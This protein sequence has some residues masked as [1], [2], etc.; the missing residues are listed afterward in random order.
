MVDD[1]TVLKI[2]LVSLS[3][4]TCNWNFKCWNYFVIL[5]IKVTFAVPN[6]KLFVKFIADICVPF[7]DHFGS[8]LD[9][10]G[11]WLFKREV[12]L[13]Q[14]DWNYRKSGYFLIRTFL[15]FVLNTKTFH[16]VS[17]PCHCIHRPMHAKFTINLI[18]K[19]WGTVIFVCEGYLAWK[20]FDLC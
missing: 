15:R 10:N 16:P 4:W 6:N 3:T 5:S 12:R 14:W 2:V 13:W 11:V 7:V 18:C 8:E 17:I 19:F 1:G 9:F 20:F